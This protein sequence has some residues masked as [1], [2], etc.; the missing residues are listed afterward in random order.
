MAASDEARVS[1]PWPER[2]EEQHAGSMPAFKPGKP[3][4]AVLQSLAG[5]KELLEEGAKTHPAFGIMK[6]ISECKGIRD[7]LRSSSTWMQRLSA[8]VFGE[9]TPPPGNFMQGSAHWCRHYPSLWHVCCM[10]PVR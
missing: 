1:C 10:Y 5:F 3:L 8:P 6:A 4:S 9:C 7:I 2:F